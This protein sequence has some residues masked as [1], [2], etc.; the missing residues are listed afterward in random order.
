MAV[1]RHLETTILD[2]RQNIWPALIVEIEPHG[3]SGSRKPAISR[4]C[5]EVE[6][7]LP[8]G[9]DSTGQKLGKNL[10]Q[11]RPASKDVEPCLNT[12]R[13]GP[14]APALGRGYRMPEIFDAATNRFEHHLCNRFSSQQHATLQF[15]KAD[16]RRVNSELGKS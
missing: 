15:K 11:P 8:R 6:H 13:A 1:K 7:L 10:W 4:R 16:P 3:H 14:D 9:P 2:F 12:A 5:A